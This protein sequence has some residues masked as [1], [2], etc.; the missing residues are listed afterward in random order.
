MSGY[1]AHL[2][3]FIRIFAFL[4]S[5][6]SVDDASMLRDAAVSLRDLLEEIGLPSWVKTSG[7]K[8]FHIAVPLDG[9]TDMDDVARFAHSVGTVL[10][11]R[12]PKNL[13][14]EFH[15]VDRGR[16]ILI[17]TGRNGWS[18]T[19]AAVYACSHEA[20]RS[21]SLRR[22]RGKE[23]ESGTVGP[24]SLTAPQHG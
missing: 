17:D 3:C 21:R 4:T 16:R 13:T 23:L 20:R 2:T 12:D 7:S 9:K 18:A 8:G 6:P 1:R 10:V 14:Q 22:A 5:D 15:K 19:H 11:K 24:R